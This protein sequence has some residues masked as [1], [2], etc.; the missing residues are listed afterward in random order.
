MINDRWR[1]SK[2]LEPLVYDLGSPG[3]RGIIAVELEEEIRNV[4]GDPLDLL[5]KEILRKTPPH[6]PEVGQ[7]RLMKH[8]VR[9]SQELTCEDNTTMFPLGTCTMKY[10]PKSHE[11]IAET[12]RFTELHPRQDE[13]TVQGILEIMYK[14]QDYLKAIS[15][16]SSVSLQPACGSQGVFTNMR[17]IRSYQE[18]KGFGMDKKDEIITTV[19]SH[20]SNPAT[21][22]MSGYKVITLYPDET[23]FP[24][25]EK[26]KAA[27]SERTAGMIIGCPDDT[28]IYNPNIMEITKAVHDAGGL[29]ILDSANA[30]GYFGWARAKEA[31]FD[32]THWNLHKSFSTPH[33][34]AGP[35]AGPIAVRED[36]AKYLPTPKINFDGERYYWDYNL[37]SSVGV[38]RPFFGNTGVILRAFAWVTSLGGEGLREVTQTAVLN[39]NYLRM[40]LEKIPGV[41]VAYETKDRLHEIRWN[42]N[43]VYAETG[44]NSFQ[45]IAR[46]CD[47][48]VGDTFPSHFPYIV[49]N[50]ITPEPTETY[51]KEEIEEYAAIVK[52]VVE[53]CYETPEIVMT[54]PHNSA[55]PHVPWETMFDPTQIAPCRTVW[56]KLQKK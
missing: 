46:I 6:L 51:S 50:P 32:M 36:L 35:G 47:Y 5:P 22:A 53:E 8:Y 49:E 25:V 42:L 18:D 48:G 44:V 16:F 38:V 28:G 4:V 40:L 12:P 2:W 17:I 26:F 15:G 37:P 7:P 13:K 56:L 1:Q 10:N 19:F 52:R 20:P 23:G 31:G 55:M 3:E 39:N 11:R 33:G 45:M 27:I 14:F 24:S 9:L 34:G 21:P 30:N 43:Q 54:A 41:Q 29:C